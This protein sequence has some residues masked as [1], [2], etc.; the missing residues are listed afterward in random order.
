MNWQFDPSHT[1]VEATA[2]HM[3]FAT[4]RVRFPGAAGEIDLDPDRPETGRVRVRI[5]VASLSSGDE[6]RD[7]HLRSA[8]F[9]DAETHPAIA[10]ASTSAQPTGGGRFRVAG[11]LTIRGATKPVVLDVALRT[12]DDP[13]VKGAKRTFVDAKTTID[14][15]EWGLVWNM[16][17]PQGVLVG[18]EIAIDVSA[19]VTEVAAVSRAA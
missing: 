12:I 15:R 10:F 11:D 19:E 8:D 3:M 17:V 6:R 18:H 9:F 14:R 7:A 1:T 13:M 16:P 5:P 4:V 2:K